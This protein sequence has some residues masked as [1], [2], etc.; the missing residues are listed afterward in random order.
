[1]RQPSYVL[2]SFIFIVVDSLIH[3]MLFLWTNGLKMHQSF[4]DF[5]FDSV[6]KVEIKNE[7]GD[8]AL[9]MTKLDSGGDS[10]GSG[11]G[12]S[13]DC[14]IEFFQKGGKIV[15]CDGLG[16]GDAEVEEESQTMVM[17][18][19]LHVLGPEDNE[20]ESANEVEDWMKTLIMDHVQN[21]LSLEDDEV[22]SVSE[23][24]QKL[25][26]EA[27]N[28]LL[29]NDDSESHVVNSESV[30]FDSKLQTVKEVAEIIDDMHN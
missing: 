8:G 1:M 10:V 22:K 16:A 26:T 25:E 4:H 3:N 19:V 27:N 29:V 13:Y 15:E 2:I 20:A 5:L 23:L 28:D 21:P 24:E 9:D 17:D 18:D 6:C 11:E 12:V 7:C 14:A 30:E